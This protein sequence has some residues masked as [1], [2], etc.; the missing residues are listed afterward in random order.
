MKKNLLV[1]SLGAGL[2]L[3]GGTGIYYVS[4]QESEGIS[5][6]NMMM[7]R[8]VNSDSN[9][10]EMMHLNMAEM[11]NGK[12]MNF[13]QMKEHLKNMHPDLSVQQLE[14]HYKSMHGTGGSEN[15]KNFQ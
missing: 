3:G 4:A 5:N 12:N 8:M 1:I 13:G 14:E 9:M 7:D 2:L 15:S 10:E 6:E 11:M